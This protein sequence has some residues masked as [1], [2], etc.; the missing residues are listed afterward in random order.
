MV[1]PFLRDIAQHFATT[2][3]HELYRYRFLFPNRRAGLFFQHYLRE[4]LGDHPALLPET[5]TVSEYL[6]RILFLPEEDVNNDLFVTYELSKVFNELMG[7]D[8]RRTFNDFYYL[9]GLILGDFNDMDKHL[10]PVDQVFRNVA[11]YQE[12]N[13]DLSFLS[14]AQRETLRT[15]FGYRGFIDN[16][17][18]YQRRFVQFWEILPALYHGTREHLKVRGLYYEGMLMREVV[19]RIAEESLTLVADRRVPVVIGFNALTPCE[20]KIF[21]HLRDSGEAIFYWDY[22]SELVQSPTLAGAFRDNA[23]RYPMPVEESIDY[24]SFDTVPSA[25]EQEVELVALPSEVA[26]AVYIGELLKEQES[27]RADIDDLKVAVVLPN[28]RLLIP[29]LS[30]VPSEL[31]NLNVTMGYPIRELPIVSMILRLLEVRMLYRR[32]GY[33]WRGEEVR[34]VLGMNPLY[35]VFGE[36]GYSR[37]CIRRLVDERWY[38]ISSTD[39]VERIALVEEPSDRQRT[40]VTLLFRDL[41]DEGPALLSWVID[42]VV[43]MSLW[44]VRKEDDDDTVVYSGADS[45]LPFLTELLMTQRASLDRY[46][47]ENGRLRDEVFGYDVVHDLLL[48]LLRQARIPYKGE[49]LKGLQVMG[50]LETRGIDFDTVIIPDAAEEILPSKTRLVGVIPYTIRQGL[51]LP[52]YKWQDQTRAYNFFRLIS[53]ARRVIATFDTRRGDHSGGEPSRYIGLLEHVYGRK[54]KRIN[55]NFPLLF[56]QRETDDMVREQERVDRYIR[57]ITE[58]GKSKLSA[59]KINRYLECPRSFYYTAILGI[60]EREEMDELISDRDMGTLVHNTVQ[61]LYMPYEGKELDRRQLASWMNE[62]THIRSTLEHAYA[63][64]FRQKIDRLTGMN[65]ITVDRAETLVRSVVAMDVESPVAVHYIGGEVEF[66]HRYTIGDMSVNLK[67]FIDRLDYIEENGQVILRVI[68]YKTGRDKLEVNLD[69][70]HNPVRD[71]NHAALQLFFY[72]YFLSRPDVARRVITDGHQDQL[73][74]TYV[75]RPMIIK[76]KVANDGLLTFS[77]TPLTDFEPLRS[78]YEQLLRD[79]LAEI[80]NPDN[81]Y[82]TTPRIHSC[83]H[84]PA[85]TFCA[86]AKND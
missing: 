18:E 84:C 16:P 52:T 46:V 49:P 4:S 50:I 65:A 28:E 61:Q 5:T 12:L 35:S 47:E 59:S 37:R 42:L 48:T 13:D 10:L 71:F 17:K 86:D 70:V 2:H 79:K 63:D 53:R 67:G 73:P 76:P 31:P 66:E 80:I 36:R 81:P 19:E 77:D 85:K 58:E 55:A 21:D 33:E 72:S 25:D 38:F 32:R 43:T 9:G 51:G 26:Q 23:K 45:V 40:L 7:E 29:V 1:N 60:D 11:D 68:D 54:V 82:D 27:L 15:F 30:N 44:L 24:V 74:P 83:I 56:E 57:S 20:V 41:K 78:E 22:L 39:V 14:D 3:G 34:E 75:V 62:H 6:R 69:D 64:L 8:Q